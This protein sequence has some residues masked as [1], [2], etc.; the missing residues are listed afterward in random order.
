M[1]AQEEREREFGYKFEEV[2]SKLENRMETLTKQLRAENLGDNARLLEHYSEGR[3]QLE[4]AGEQMKR[5]LERAYEKGARALS[6]A[7][8]Y[9]VGR[10]TH[11]GGD[12]F[13]GE[14]DAG[15]RAGAAEEPADGV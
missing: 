13:R 5:D 8:R 15:R 1:C 10:L 2:Q 7:V 9:R 14:Q 12:F 11:A 3:A 6:R 4:E